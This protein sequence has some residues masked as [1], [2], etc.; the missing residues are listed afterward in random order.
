MKRVDP[1][2]NLASNNLLLYIS[3]LVCKEINL[4]FLK[5]IVHI[6]RIFINLKAKVNKKLN[7][8][9]EIEKL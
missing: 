9:T 3:Y 5:E 1:N 8:K 6:G 4:Y 7:N 2:T